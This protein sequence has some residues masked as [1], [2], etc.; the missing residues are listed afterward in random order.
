M[1]CDE[2]LKVDALLQQKLKVLQDLD[3]E[4]ELLITKAEQ[5]HHQGESDGNDGDIHNNYE[6]FVLF[7]NPDDSLFLIYLRL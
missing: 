1:F 3:Q 5:I 2:W 6:C 4:R 7:Q